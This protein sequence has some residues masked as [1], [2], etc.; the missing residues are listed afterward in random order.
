MKKQKMV[1]AVLMAAFLAYTLPCRAD[2]N[3]TEYECCCALTC[4]WSY[5]IWNPVCQ[6]KDNATGTVYAFY[7]EC[8]DWPAELELYCTNQAYADGA[9]KQESERDAIELV[10]EKFS[11]ICPEA[12]MGPIVTVSYVGPTPVPCEFGVKDDCS[13]FD[14]TGPDDSRLEMLRLFR[15]EVLGAS[16]AG[17]KLTRLYYDTSG[18]L[19]RIFRRHPDIKARARALLDKAS[20]GIASF[21]AGTSTD[22]GLLSG[23]IAAEA[24]AVIDDIEAV[25]PGLLKAPLAALLEQI[26]NEGG[27][28]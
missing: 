16:P 18:E 2:D 7:A 15:D 10:K 20:P 11:T 28:Q 27:L 23:D 3:D 5:T 6:G 21:S 13:I 9:C 19:I 22:A 17:R 25:S 8:R 1:L 24:D 4:Q 26:K 12:A 14:L